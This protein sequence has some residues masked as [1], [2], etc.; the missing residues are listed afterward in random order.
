M[1]RACAGWAT[2]GLASESL[3]VIEKLDW[4]GSGRFFKREDARRKIPANERARCVLLSRFSLCRLRERSEVDMTGVR[5]ILEVLEIGVLVSTGCCSGG[6]GITIWASAEDSP[7]GARFSFDG[8]SNHDPELLLEVAIGWPAS[9]SGSGRVFS[10]CSLRLMNASAPRS[11]KLRR[12]SLSRSCR[13]SLESIAS[14]N[15]A[16]RSVGTNGPAGI[17]SLAVEEDDGFLLAA[18]VWKEV[19]VHFNLGLGVHASNAPTL[20]ARVE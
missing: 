14:A 18:G 13:K 8:S 6:C 1:S 7:F 4:V 16:I 2:G 9:A 15:V 10:C 17:L 19:S 20:K 12:W 11:R 3:D 5:G